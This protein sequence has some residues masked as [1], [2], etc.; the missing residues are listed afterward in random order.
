[1]TTT[2]KL[3]RIPRQPS[4]AEGEGTG[5]EFAEVTTLATLSAVERPSTKQ[6]LVLGLL[7]SDGGVP[8]QAILEATGWQAHTAR[9][10][11][12]GLRKKGHAI[13]RIK[14]DGVTRYAIP[15]LSAQ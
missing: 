14:V 13:A 1:M 7:H 15:A 10:A 6:A 2:K 12:T 4:N 9:A 3:R 8:L 5:A 11:L